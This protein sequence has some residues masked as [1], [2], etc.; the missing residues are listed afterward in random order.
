MVTP[1]SSAE[2]ERIRQMYIDQKQDCLLP[3]SKLV[4]WIG[5]SYYNS[6]H[7][8]SKFFKANASILGLLRP[9]IQFIDYIF[10]RA[11]M[12]DYDIRVC[13]DVIKVTV[14]C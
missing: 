5:A 7:Y 3:E 6:K 9:F 11:W 2:N 12:C 13:I 14:C 10:Y 1:E 4:G 8:A